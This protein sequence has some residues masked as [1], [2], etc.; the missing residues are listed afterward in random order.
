MK[1]LVTGS[2]GFLGSAIV[3]RLIVH[4]ER[5][6]RC[7]VRPGSQRG[8]LDF[9][10]SAHPEAALEIF[11]GSLATVESAAAALDGIEMVYHVAA[12][13]S[14]PAADLFLAS[15]VASKNLL[16][17]MVRRGMV[18]TVLISSFG[19]Y[20]ASSLPTGATLDENCP[21]ERHGEKRDLYSFA[22]IR[23][24]KLFWE[25]V[26]RYDLP[27]TVLRP[28][29]IYGPGNPGPSTRVGISVGPLFLFFGGG[30]PLPLS[31]VENCAEAAVIA[32]GREDTIGQ[33]FNVHDDDL[34]T[35]AQYLKLYRKEVK[36]LRVLSI[37]YPV[38]M[39]LSRQIE[40]YS[41]NSNGQIP[42]VFTPYKTK[43]SWK[44]TQFDN[45]KLK[46]IGWKQVVSTI[47]GT[48]TTLH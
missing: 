23:Q 46:K 37:P 33:V 32:G 4:G 19:V 13:M 21:L 29:V 2:N 6:I 35:C 45:S 22:K 14:G 5:D 38:L 43:N 25:Y 8:R 24:E 27:L 40:K 3:E 18:R 26:K 42:P 7:F 48:S 11:E 31:Y 1:I 15:V 16:E 12:G 17:A 20:E 47:K 36:S 9:V 30:N 34:P 28:G 39:L 44:R 41:K 10:Q